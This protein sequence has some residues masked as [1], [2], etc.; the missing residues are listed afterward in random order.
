MP[1]Q[2][3]ITLADFVT[4]TYRHQVIL[5][6][7]INGGEIIVEYLFFGGEEL[8]HVIAYFLSVLTAIIVLKGVQVNTR[9]VQS[10][11]L[12]IPSFA[13]HSVQGIQIV[14][15]FIRI[16]CN[17]VQLANGLYLLRVQLEHLDT[18]LIV[19]GHLLKDVLDAV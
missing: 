15:K 18:D 16:A 3:M 17:K 7:F 19:G 14:Q 10:S 4:E 1:T 13:L 8:F 11:H 6:W 12:N 9:E 2:Q 5:I